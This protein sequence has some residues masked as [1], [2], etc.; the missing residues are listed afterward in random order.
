MLRSPLFLPQVFGF[1]EMA[2]VGEKHPDLG[3]ILGT[4][5]ATIDSK[6]RILL[7]K[8]KRDRL[9]ETFAVAIGERECICAYPLAKWQERLDQVNRYD[10]NNQGRQ[11]YERLFYGS[12]DDDIS[13]DAQGRV[14]IPEKLRKAGKLKEKVLL[15]GCNNRLEIWDV[16]EYEKYLA[17]QNKEGQDRAEALESAYN[18]MMGVSTSQ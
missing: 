14:V 8:K 17:K 13:C 5:E 16:D 18:K 7:S 1:V 2:A 15:V 6:G 9:G 4:D 10:P 3:P 11:E 12:A